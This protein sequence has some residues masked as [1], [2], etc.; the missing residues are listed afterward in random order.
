LLDE[1]EMIPTNE[2]V[3]ELAKALAEVN[4][5]RWCDLMDGGAGGGLSQAVASKMFYMRLAKTALMYVALQSP[6]KAA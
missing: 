2:E 3:A 4:G 5:Y 6:A 1:E